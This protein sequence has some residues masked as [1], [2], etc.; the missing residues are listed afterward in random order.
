MAERCRQSANRR[1]IDN[2]SGRVFSISRF[3]SVR[4]DNSAR[5]IT[6][7]AASLLFI[8]SQAIN[9]RVKN[10]ELSIALAETELIANRSRKQINQ[11]V[12]ASCKIGCHNMH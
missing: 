5:I 7:E 12:L 1:D 6:M 2:D 4:I 9:L 11:T 10:S 3:F 8:S